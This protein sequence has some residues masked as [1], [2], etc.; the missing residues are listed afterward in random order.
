MTKQALHHYL[1]SRELAVL[2][3]SHESAPE[4][5][6]LAFAVTPELEIIFDTVKASRKYANLTA[7]S[8]WA[9]A[10][11]M[12]RPCAFQNTTALDS[13]L[14]LQEDLGPDGRD[15]VLT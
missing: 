6:L 10:L 8:G 14:R 2:A 3:T 11:E 9:R 12:A 13:I 4:A 1:A 7:I 15:D 5:A